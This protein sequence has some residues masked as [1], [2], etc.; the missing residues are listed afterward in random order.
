MAAA[1]AVPPA[2]RRALNANL[3]TITNLPSTVSL[4]CL[5]YNVLAGVRVHD[6][7]GHWLW[8]AVQRRH[9]TAAPPAPRCPRVGAPPTAQAALQLLLVQQPPWEPR[10]LGRRHT[11]RPSRTGH[12]EYASRRS[13]RSVGMVYRRG[14]SRRGDAPRQQQRQR[15]RSSGRDDVSGCSR[16]CL[17]AY[18]DLAFFRY[19]RLLSPAK[20][21]QS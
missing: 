7:G 20:A 12:A 16:P 17:I 2:A 10:A 6:D 13:L 21:S 3:G 15:D 11:T 14:R 4:A 5:T 8:P 19:N 1:P 18:Y 9:D